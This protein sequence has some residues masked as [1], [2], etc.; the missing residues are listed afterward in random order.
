MDVGVLDE[1]LAGQLE[2]LFLADLASSVEIV[3]PTT[4]APAS[5][6]LHGG[7][8]VPRTSLEPEGT[9]PQRLERGLRQ[10]GGSTGWRIADLVRAGSIFGDALAGHRPLGREDRTVL[11]TVSSAALVLAVVVALVPHWA[12]W[13][14]AGALG[15]LGGT[16]TVRAFLE[17]RRALARD[18]R[19]RTKHETPTEN[20]R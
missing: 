15:W 7:T 11:G 10:R 5:E 3:L 16:G 13:V 4:R 17:K 12:G 19:E 2:G 6:P 14:L 20:D 1:G 18:A 9:L 8:L